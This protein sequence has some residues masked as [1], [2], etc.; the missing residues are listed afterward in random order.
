MISAVLLTAFFLGSVL[1]ILRTIY[2]Q[3]FN[4]YGDVRIKIRKTTKKHFEKA[5]ATTNNT[6]FFQ[7][8]SGVSLLEQ[9]KYGSC[10]YAGVASAIDTMKILKDS[11][12]DPFEF[13]GIQSDLLKEQLQKESDVLNV[14]TIQLSAMTANEGDVELNV[15]IP[16]ETN[17]FSNTSL[18][19][20]ST[21]TRSSFYT[22]KSSS[23]SLP[24]T[25]S[26]SPS[27]STGSSTTGFEL[28]SE[29]N[30]LKFSHIRTVDDVFKTMRESSF[31]LWT[32]SRLAFQSAFN[33]ELVSFILPNKSHV[34]SSWLKK[35]LFTDS[36]SSLRTGIECYILEQ[37]GLIKNIDD[38]L[39]G[40]QT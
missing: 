33:R 13:F 1:L 26:K 35:E 7:R 5:S 2:S 4:K 32:V 22:L 19:S 23:F 20:P 27:S 15:S 36:A 12:V 3:L 18:Y 38:S 24:T 17:N 6:D 8:V 28:V 29:S 14:L 11:K 10:Q 21:P 31:D 37:V 16:L 39:E 34:P 40:F 25:S 9:C 30:A